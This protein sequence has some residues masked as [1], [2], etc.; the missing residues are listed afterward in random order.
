[1]IIEHNKETELFLREALE[2]LSMYYALNDICSRVDNTIISVEQE[3][4]LVSIYKEYGVNIKTIKYSTKELTDNPYYKNIKL[5]NIKTNNI[6]YSNAKLPARACI[7]MG[8][9]KYADKLYK[10]YVDMGY[11]DRSINI[12]R[13]MEGDRVWMSPTIAEQRSIQPHI[14]KAKGKVLTFGLGIGYYVYMCLLK[15]EVEDITIV[16]INKDIIDLFNEYIKPQFPDTKNINIIHGDMYDYYNDKFMS[17]FNTIFVDTWYNNTDAL[18]QYKKL[19]KIK[20]DRTRISYWIEESILEVIRVALL[21]YIMSIYNDDYTNLISRIS[22]ENFKEITGI[23]KY[24]KENNKR[25]STYKQ[26]EEL[27]NNVEVLR[28]IAGYMG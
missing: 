22:R 5:N 24:F 7:N 2:S 14:D 21:A 12:P 9:T 10:S 23:N 3:K 8:F 27:I 16:E 28:D 19:Q 6:K 17:N 26:M 15:E 25:Y 4:A 13:L 18:E 11:F 20:V 1:M